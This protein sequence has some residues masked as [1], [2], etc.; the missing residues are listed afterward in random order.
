[1]YYTIIYIELP[2][3]SDA[4]IC[5]LFCYSYWIIIECLYYVLVIYQ[6]P[7]ISQLILPTNIIPCYIRNYL[8]IKVFLYKNNLF[9]FLCSHI[10][11][12]GSCHE[13]FYFKTNS[14]FGASIFLLKRKVIIILRTCQSV[15]AAITK[16]HSLGT[17]RT[18]FWRLEVQNK[19]GGIVGFLWRPSLGLQTVDLLLCPH[20]VEGANISLGLL[21]QDH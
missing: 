2:F 20:V 12:H 17:Y 16:Y 19:D 13:L 14:H 18:Q 10:Y 5:E 6:M 9:C 21:L 15:Q 8:K 3:H 4:S 11:K 7:I 1:M